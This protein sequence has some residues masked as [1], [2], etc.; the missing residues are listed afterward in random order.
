MEN[1]FDDQERARIHA[2]VDVLLRIVDRPSLIVQRL[3]YEDTDRRS[4]RA[5]RR[6]FGGEP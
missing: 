4:A 3:M 6:L 2:E 5:R 1:K